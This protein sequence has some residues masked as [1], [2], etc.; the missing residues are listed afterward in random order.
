MGGVFWAAVLIV[1]DVAA[2]AAMGWYAAGLVGFVIVQLGFL[3]AVSIAT[4]C[5][6]AHAAAAGTLALISLVF[7]ATT[8]VAIALA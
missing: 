3:A 6:R 8:M 1:A 7:A 4:A 5:L 2:S